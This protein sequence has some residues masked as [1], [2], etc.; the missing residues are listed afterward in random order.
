MAISYYMIKIG[1]IK[2]VS[3]TTNIPSHNKN[4]IFL[5]KF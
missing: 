3:A 5:I 4:A 2:F 1:L